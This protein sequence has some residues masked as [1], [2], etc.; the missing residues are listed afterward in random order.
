MKSLTTDP[1]RRLEL[2]FDKAS[3]QMEKRFEGLEQQIG[4]IEVNLSNNEARD[5]NRRLFKMHHAITAP[6]MAIPNRRDADCTAYM[7][8]PDV[9]KTMKDLYTLA[10]HAKG[11][12][13]VSWDRRYWN[14]KEVF[15]SRSCDK[16]KHSIALVNLCLFSTRDSYHANIHLT[17]TGDAMSQATKDLGDLAE[18][19]R[20]LI[21]E[22]DSSEGITTQTPVEPSTVDE[23]MSSFLDEWGMDW[24]KVCEV[25]EAYAKEPTRP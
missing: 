22:T 3:D 7:Y 19:Y 6:L 5:R 9:P 13:P 21:C 11:I 17:G 12:F 10:Q 1:I 4:A 14:G 2:K 18:Y 23:Y 25:A 8:H 15:T 16:F 20:A 24:S